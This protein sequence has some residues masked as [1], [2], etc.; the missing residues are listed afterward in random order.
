MSTPHPR[1]DI[2]HNRGQG[3]F[4]LIEMIV[5]LAIAVI[6][7]SIFYTF[8]GNSLDQAAE[9]A[10]KDALEDLRNMIRQTKNCPETIAAMH[11]NCSSGVDGIR[12]PTPIRLISASGTDLIGISQPTDG[13]AQPQFTQFG[14]FNLRASCTATFG[15]IKIEYADVGK[16]NWQDL[17][18]DPPFMCWE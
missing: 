13:L 4:S 1:Q 3:G 14:K 17:F 10:K 8:V 2:N 12:I 11:T 7:G 15:E 16:N 5:G 6:A 9:I 18:T